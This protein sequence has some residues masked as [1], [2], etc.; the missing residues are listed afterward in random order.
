M[1]KNNKFNVDRTSLIRL[2]SFSIRI[3]GQVDLIHLSL[4]WLEF[5][6]E[7]CL[8]ILYWLFISF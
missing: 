8:L 3:N 7:I 5:N 4:S 1:I 2:Y 6:I